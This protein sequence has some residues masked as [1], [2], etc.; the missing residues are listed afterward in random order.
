MGSRAGQ[1]RICAASERKYQEKL[2]KK[3]REKVKKDREK[4]VVVQERM[5][6]ANKITGPERRATVGVPSEIL[7]K[8]A[9]VFSLF[10]KKTTTGRQGHSSAKVA[11]TF[12]IKGGA[13]YWISQDSLASYARCSGFGLGLEM[14]LAQFL[15][16]VGKIRFGTVP[17]RLSQSKQE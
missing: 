1:K 12:S 11:G 6:K 15:C 8:I 16:K 4:K 2:R 7:S 9:L 5:K 13:S 17:S 14:T 10:V 3:Q